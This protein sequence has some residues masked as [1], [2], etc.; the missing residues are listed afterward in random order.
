VVKLTRAGQ[1]DD[2]GHAADCERTLRQRLERRLTA[3]ELRVLW[4]ALAVLTE[5]IRAYAL[6]GG[7]RQPASA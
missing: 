2:Q 7:V 6:R 1:A 3:L 4:K 5:E